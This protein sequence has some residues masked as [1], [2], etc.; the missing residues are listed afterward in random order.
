MNES[1]TMTVPSFKLYFP[2]EDVATFQKY[3]ADILGSGMLT[4]GKY[5]KMLE[6][7]CSAVLGSKY[8]VAVNSG[9]SAIEIALRASRIRDGEVIV[10]T[11]T[12]AATATATI[13]SGNRVKFAEIEEA[14]LCASK[15][16]IEDQI[17]QSTKAVVM[18]HIAG[19]VS[20]EIVEIAELCESK[21][22]ALIEDAAHAFGSSYQGRSAG[23][24][25]SAGCFSFY[26]T[27]VV[28]SAEGG[29]VVTDSSEIDYVTRILRDQGKEAFNSNTVVELGFNW[30]IS[31]L[32]AAVGI[33]AVRR[34]REIVERRNRIASIYDKIL[35]GCKNMTLVRTPKSCINNYYKYVILLRQG[36]DRDEYKMKVKERGVSC[37]GEVYVPPLHLQPIFQQIY[38]TKKGDFPIAEDVCDGMVCL[39]MYQT[40]DDKTAEHVATIARNVADSY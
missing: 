16:T 38:G 15:S 40:I 35:D 29:L 17:T 9:S 19:I 7:D 5:T 22:I 37:S 14:T 6:S 32:D 23:R 11:N 12:F 27:K 28:T 26:P 33:I 8:A 13:F 21:G 18:V 1:S 24:F 2:P 20:P 4:L 31:E 39:P 30:R 25:G 3:S 36:I 10:P 34:I